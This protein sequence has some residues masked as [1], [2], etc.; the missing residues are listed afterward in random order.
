MSWRYQ[1]VWIEDDHG[2]TYTMIEVY[3][4]E[5]GNFTRWTDGDS[6]P[7]GETQD[8]LSSDLHR[9]LID[10]MCWVPA[11]RDDLQPGFRFERRVSMEDRL[12]LIDFVGETKDA[13]E[14]QPKPTPN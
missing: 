11:K 14:R 6:C 7:A 12:A 8:E 3:F 10:A 13:M 4:D 2:R 5:A 9:M 1:P